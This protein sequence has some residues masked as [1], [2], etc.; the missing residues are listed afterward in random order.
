MTW[1]DHCRG[2]EEGI[3]L[4]DYPPTTSKQNMK[5]NELKFR[6]R[7]KSVMGWPV[8]VTKVSE[9][10]E[11]GEG[12][13]PIVSMVNKILKGKRFTFEEAQELLPQVRTVHPEAEIVGAPDMPRIV[14]LCGSTRFY[15]TFAEQNL[16]LT[17]SGIIVL[18]IGMSTGSDAEHLANG[19]ITEADKLKFDELHKRKIDLCDAVIVLNV[20][21]YIGE[22]TRSEILYAEENGKSVGYLEPKPLL[23]LKG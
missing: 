8:W 9:P 20:G 12:K 1:W 19:T 22:S 18:S 15:K 4:G 7:A 13:A 5:I 23:A 21:G 14:C 10:V 16:E 11:T 17:K 2:G 3:E 6:I